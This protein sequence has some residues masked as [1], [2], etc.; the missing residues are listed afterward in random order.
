[1]HSSCNDKV[2]SRQSGN[3]GSGEYDIRDR[4]SLLVGNRRSDTIRRGE[5]TPHPYKT[6]NIKYNYIARFSSL[7]IR[8]KINNDMTVSTV[9][10]VAKAAAIP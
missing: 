6:L 4:A 8:L 3:Q 9:K 7:D 5:G 2:N 10:I 1:M